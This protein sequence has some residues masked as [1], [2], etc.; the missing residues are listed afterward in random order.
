MFEQCVWLNEPSDRHLEAGVLNV[1]IVSGSNDTL[2]V[3]K[4]DAC[5]GR[6]GKVAA[7]YNV[8]CNG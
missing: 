4:L 3:T 7:A 1:T 6:E 2:R 5:A 8:L